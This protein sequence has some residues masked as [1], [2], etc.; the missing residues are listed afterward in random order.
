MGFL[1]RQISKPKSCRVVTVTLCNNQSHLSRSVEILVNAFTFVYSLCFIYVFS[2]KF[3]YYNRS[4]IL[5][6][7]PDKLFSISIFFNSQ[8]FWCSCIAM[9]VN[10]YWIIMCIPLFYYNSSSTNLPSPP[11]VPRHSGGLYLHKRFGIVL[12]PHYT[13]DLPYLRHRS[14]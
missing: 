5:V 14:F 2:F 13:N 9:D 6:K 4:Q 11:A 1:W 10:R 8:L 3:I 12:R 7:N